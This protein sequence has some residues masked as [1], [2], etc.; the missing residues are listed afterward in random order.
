MGEIATL[1]GLVTNY[2]LPAVL[3]V[4]VFAMYYRANQQTVSIYK[5]MLTREMEDNEKIISSL[6]AIQTQLTLLIT[7]QGGKS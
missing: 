2:G 3:L 5:E 1:A 7:Q 6:S 4:I